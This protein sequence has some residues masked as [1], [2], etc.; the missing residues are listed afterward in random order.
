MA[1]QL[2]LH[3]HQSENRQRYSQT[4]LQAEHKYPHP[5]NQLQETL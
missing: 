5:L 3:L 4:V 1:P 2:Q